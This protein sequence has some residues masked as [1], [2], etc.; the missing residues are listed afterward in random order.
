MNRA[1][2][3]ATIASL[4]P[5]MRQAWQPFEQMPESERPEIF[6]RQRER[7]GDLQSFWKNNIY[8]V[9]I[10]RRAT[11]RGVALQLVVRRHDEEEI[12]GWDDLQRVKNELAGPD[13]VAVEIYPPQHELMDQAPL[14]HLFVLPVGEAAPFTLH[15]GWR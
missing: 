1:S 13:R 11:K 9:Q 15:G 2:R 6:A 5:G 4:R 12:Q 14:R 7:V 3:R 8:S 10:Y